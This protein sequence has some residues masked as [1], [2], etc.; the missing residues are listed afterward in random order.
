MYTSLLL[1]YWGAYIAKGDPTAELILVTGHTKQCTINSTFHTPGQYGLGW[2]NTSHML[3]ICIHV[4]G[5]KWTAEYMYL[6][7][8]IYLSCYLSKKSEI[9]WKPF[10]N[11]VTCTNLSFTPWMMITKCCCSFFFVIKRQLVH[12]NT[13]LVPNTYHWYQNML[14]AFHY[15]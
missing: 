4:L 8:W 3:I 1:L 10:K 2:K 12:Q 7:C 14:F 13:S 9:F 11:S 5:Y 6:Q 15:T